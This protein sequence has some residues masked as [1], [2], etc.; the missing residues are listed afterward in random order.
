MPLL[1]RLIKK[2][3][4]LRSRI[5]PK[6]VSATELQA[7]TLR[8]LLLTAQGTDFG[9]TYKFDYIAGSALPM[10]AFRETVPVFDYDK[11]FNEWWYRTLDQEY[12]VSWP[13]K[14]QYF[15]LSS[16]TSGAP[17][18]HIPVSE[19]MIKA[20]RRASTEMFMQLA[21][22]DEIDDG[23]FT[24]QMM[25]LGSSSKLN[26]E[27]G[28]YMGDLSGINAGRIPLW[29]QRYY[30]PGKKIASIPD[31]DTRMMEIAKASSRWD[32]GALSG[33]PAWVQL[34]LERVMD[35]NNAQ[36]IH[37]V[38]P[39]LQ[40]YVTG[41]V[42]FEP[43][44]ASFNKLFS[45]EVYYLDTYLASEGFVAFQNRIEAN[46]MKL[47]LGNGI[48][49][50]FIPFNEENFESDGEMRPNPRVLTLEEVKE[51]QDYA[52]L[53]STCSGTWRYLIGDTVRF[54]DLS[55]CEIII[56][57]RTKHFLSI[58][59]EHLSVDNMN[60]AIGQLALEFGAEIKEF[61]VAGIPFDGLFAHKW[62]IGSNKAIDNQLFAEKLD[63]KL[64]EINAD[65]ATERRENALKSVMVEVIPT[66]IFY[67]W[68]A[69]KGKMGG[70]S[71]FPRVMKQD[72]FDEWEAFVLKQPLGF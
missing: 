67:R 10:Q 58:C 4:Q 62:Y 70:Q 44:K 54:T 16:G 69:S 72:R 27:G 21:L 1:G 66:E 61:T 55:R 13:G 22:L 57:G 50:E 63:F 26:D 17:S 25:M 48:Y 3:I 32:V 49:F 68:H 28:Y 46:A 11:I 34:M 19:E 15:A 36:Y 45:R 40:V 52:I 56:T 53:L 20:M 64:R 39:N 65:Y 47:V 41:G 33:I 14:I 7:R 6:N 5:N 35:Y 12:N 9:Q 31:Y 37:D 42:A 24:K 30:K 23:F 18:K 2:G 60:H 43:Y 59:G 29:F 8:H 71:K 51:G 38:W